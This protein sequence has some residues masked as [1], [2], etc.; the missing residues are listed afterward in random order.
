MNQTWRVNKTNYHTKG[1]ARGL[2]LKQRRNATQKSPIVC[3][4][5]PGVSS[6]KKLQLLCC[7]FREHVNELNSTNYHGNYTLKACNWNLYSNLCEL[8]ETRVRLIKYTCSFLTEFT[9]THSGEHELQ[10]VRKEDVW[11]ISFHRET[12][13]LTKVLK[14]QHADLIYIIGLGFARF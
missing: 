13:I 1:F 6:I 10:W 9:P 2:A 14:L 12:R 7:I 3:M 8:V 11:E 5:I 4:L